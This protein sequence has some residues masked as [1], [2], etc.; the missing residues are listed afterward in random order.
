[1]NMKDR[2]QGLI[3]TELR[4]DQSEFGPGDGP[5]QQKRLQQSQNEIES[6]ENAETP[7]FSGWGDC[8]QYL[9]V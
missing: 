5:F 8:L 4:G 1:M 2:N 3:E 6:T 9:L 7:T